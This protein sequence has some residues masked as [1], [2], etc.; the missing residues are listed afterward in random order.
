MEKFFLPLTRDPQIRISCSYFL[1]PERPCPRETLIVFLNG[2]DNP[3]ELWSQTIAA[4]L[5]PR[6]RPNSTPILTYDRPGQGATIGRNADAP[7]RPK[8]HGR[9]CLDAAYDLRDMIEKVGAMRLG[10]KA[11][12]ID[13]LG[14][15]FVAASIG[16]AIARLYAAEYPKTVTAYL[17]MDSTLSNSDAVSSYPDPRAPDFAESDLPHGITAADLELARQAMRLYYHPEALNKEGL[18]RG[19]LPELLPYSDSPLL[20]GPGP[21]T[22]YLT[23]MQHDMEVIA[24]QWKKVRFQDTP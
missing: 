3:K 12:D 24:V 8:D 23:V 16:V 1:P 15:V 14:I 11:T 7:G 13:S 22:P 17:F 4:L 5:K 21:K 18:W 2:V 19:N 20:V 10:I 6:R 9:D